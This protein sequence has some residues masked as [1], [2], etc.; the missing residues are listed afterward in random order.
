MNKSWIYATAVVAALIG[1]GWQETKPTPPPQPNP[2]AKLGVPKL[3]PRVELKPPE[4]AIPFRD[5]PRGGSSIPL[6]HNGKPVTPSFENYWTDRLKAGVL[7]LKHK[8][9]MPIKVPDPNMDYKIQIITPNP[10]VNLYI[11]NGLPREDPRV[12]APRIDNLLKPKLQDTKPR[13]PEK[14]SAPRKGEKK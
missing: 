6:D 13:E 3:A 8:Y 9:D 2:K 10:E 7:T 1:L 11:P 12:V 14:K 4:G 5:L